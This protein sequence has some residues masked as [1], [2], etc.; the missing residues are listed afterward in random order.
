MSARPDDRMSAVERA[1]DDPDAA[2]L[3]RLLDDGFSEEQVPRL[4]RGVEQR[5]LRTSFTRRHAAALLAAAVLLVVLGAGALRF[6]DAGT[7]LLL[8]SGDTPAVLDAARGRVESRFADGSRIELD[9]G[10]RMEVLRND[11]RS[12]VSVLQRGEGVFEV[13]PGGPRR[14]IVH[15]GIAN[16]EV[17]GT[18]FRVSR[19]AGRVE[20]SVTRGVVMVLAESLPGG[21]V[22]LSA[23]NTLVVRAPA[24]LDASARPLPKAVQGAAS[25]APASPTLAPSTALPLEAAPPPAPSSAVRAQPA[26]DAIDELFRAA[27]RARGRGDTAAAV[28]AYE[29]VLARASARDPR[30]GLA[31]MSLTR[32]TLRGDPAR[33]ASAL[34]GS[35]TGMPSALAED[36]LARQVEAEG[37]SGRV[38]EAA[39]LARLYLGRF[40]DGRHEADV[41]RWLPP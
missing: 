16:V 36:A 17:I 3:G 20:V 26:T 30:R 27:D 18:R 24:E 34:D 28:A 15:A 8:S 12:F 2:P 4:W 25:A 35:M 22:R 5:A 13:E 23:G 1:L 41:R 37:R 38:D 7:P 14:W 29:A 32:L 39:R 31:A 40:P 33:A 10:S 19:A 21:A 9:P 6:F 11:G